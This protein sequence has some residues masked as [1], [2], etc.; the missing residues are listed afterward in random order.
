MT[1]S[2]LVLPEASRTANAKATGAIELPSWDTVCPV[3]N[4]RKSFCV[5]GDES[6]LGFP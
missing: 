6:K 5:I 1:P 2:W 4:Q 3:K